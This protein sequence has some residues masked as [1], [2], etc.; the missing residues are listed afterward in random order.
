MTLL[1][2][3]PLNIPFDATTCYCSILCI[4]SEYTVINK[5]LLNLIVFDNFPRIYS[6]CAKRFAYLGPTHFRYY[7]RCWRNCVCFNIFHEIFEALKM[8]A[9]QQFQEIRLSPIL[10]KLHVFLHLSAIVADLEDDGRFSAIF[11]NFS[12]LLKK[13]HV[14]QHFS[15]SSRRCWRRCACLLVLVFS[16]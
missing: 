6:R 14:L 7:C 11:S 5:V 16:L 8:F 4:S 2:Y 13:M 3:V 12:M 10:K 15:L 1:A 9:L